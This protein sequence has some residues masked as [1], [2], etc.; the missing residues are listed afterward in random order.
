VVIEPGGDGCDIREGLQG[1]EH[2]TLWVQATKFVPLFDLG[3][4]PLQQAVQPVGPDHDAGFGQVVGEAGGL[5]E[6]QRQVVLDPAMCNAVRY[7][8][9]HARTPRLTLEAFP[10]A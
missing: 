5:L 3:P 1:I 10:V 6:E 7:V 4:G 2:G 9:I 8:A